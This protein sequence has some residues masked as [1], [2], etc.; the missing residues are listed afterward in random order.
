[1]WPSLA[2]DA[3]GQVA[4][5]VLEARVA[6]G[7]ACA[8]DPGAGRSPVGAD[9]AGFLAAANADQPQGAF[10]C[11]CESRQLVGTALTTCQQDSGEIGQAAG[12][13]YV[14][15]TTAPPTGNPGLLKSCPPAAQRVLRFVGEGIPLPNSTAFIVCAGE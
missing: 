12:F 10:T 8:C 5:R 7:A 4:C 1:M 9:G 14:D 2:T 11:A 15:A 3:I 6:S 13:C